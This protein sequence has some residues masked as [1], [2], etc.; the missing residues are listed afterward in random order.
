MKSCT[1]VV[2]EEYL[3]YY[4][5]SLCYRSMEAFEIQTFDKL[6]V[7]IHSRLYRCYYA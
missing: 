1:R 4:Y 3:I 7:F 2:K 5:Y 6:E